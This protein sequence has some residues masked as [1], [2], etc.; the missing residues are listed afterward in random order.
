MVPLDVA[1]GVLMKSRPWLIGG[2]SVG[3][4]LALTAG[5]P[6]T[7]APP[8]GSLRG[9]V[10]HDADLSGVRD[11]GEHGV[12]A[13]TVLAVD[14]RGAQVGSTTTRDDGT[15]DLAVTTAASDVL[16]VEL[17]PPGGYA[18][19]PHSGSSGT[20]VEFVRVGA[21][22]LNF[23]L[24]RSGD[25]APVHGVE[26]GDRVWRDLDEDGLQDPQEPP[27]PG[28]T[29]SLWGPNGRLAVAVT[30]AQG[31]FF[32]SSLRDDPAQPRGSASRIYGLRTLQPL[33]EY[34]FRLD[35]P[36]DYASGPL[37]RLTPSRRTAGSNPAIDSDGAVVSMFA[38]ASFQAP[39]DGSAD[40][41]CDFGFTRI[42][43]RVRGR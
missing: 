19:A 40:H 31:R 43:S 13:A 3:L 25:P 1:Q 36:M 17:R 6:G 33:A 14:A 4:V 42:P 21:G 11:T 34:S 37:K 28:V 39:P 2:V 10:F 9:V 27:I 30:D 24:S 7:A 41:S 26:V 15:Y 29:V 5:A 16:R 20:T 18:P 35:N 38:R 12:P 32:F 22:P 23:G 8:T